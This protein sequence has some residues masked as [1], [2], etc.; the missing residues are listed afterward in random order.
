MD[1][2]MVYSPIRFLREQRE[3]GS[4]NKKQALIFC[5]N[6]YVPGKMNVKLM[7][8]NYIMN[9]FAVIPQENL[10]IV[11]LASILN[12]AVSWAVMTNGKLEKRGPITMKRLETVFVRM[13]PELEQQVVA[14]LYYL[15]MD[16]RK[17][18]TNGDNRQ[19]LDYWKSVYE[20]LLNAIALELVLP[21]V[22]KV[23]EIE[24]LESWC[25]L[26]GKCLKEYPNYKW[27]QWQEY[28]GKELLTPQNVVIGNLNKLRVVMND[29]VEQVKVKI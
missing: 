2:G 10:N 15:L 23:Y 4:S 1:V 25:S 13:L 16:I 6:M 27:I 22:F 11:Y 26:I 24:M 12:T 21:E 18:E 9:G 3:H 5:P 28:L 17:Q 8:D 20:Q 29:V 7:E 19:Y 14:Y